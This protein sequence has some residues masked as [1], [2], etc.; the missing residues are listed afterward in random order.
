VDFSRNLLER[1]PKENFFY[2][3]T[4]ARK[5]KMSQ[6]RIVHLPDDIANMVKLEILELDSNKLTQLP[7]G[8]SSLAGTIDVGGLFM[9]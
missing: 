1:L 9:F 8:L 3:M 2:W 7:D 6:N 5:L 4:E